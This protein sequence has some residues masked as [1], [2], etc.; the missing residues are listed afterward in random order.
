MGDCKME[1]I[2]C[3]VGELLHVMAGVDKQ[4]STRRRSLMKLIG[5]VQLVL[6]RVSYSTVLSV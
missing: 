3:W 2:E 5:Q 6:Y 1:I 4:V